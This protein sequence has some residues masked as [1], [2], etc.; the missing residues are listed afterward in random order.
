M[1]FGEKLQALRKE[2]GI[3]QEALAEMLGVSR[4][5]VSKW[6]SGATYPETEKI[7]TLCRMYD[8]SADEL[9]LDQP[10]Q[11]MPE[12]LPPQHTP[13][14]RRWATPVLAAA[15]A[16]A[17]AV[18]LWQFNRV[19]HWKLE[20]L[21]KQDRLAA[22]EDNLADHRVTVEG[23]QEL[24][25]GLQTENGELK[26]QLAAVPAPEPFSDPQQ[27]EEA[28]R[29]FFYRFGQ[30]WR[31]DYLP[32]FAA[33]QAPKES[34]DYLMWAYT[35]NAGNWSAEQDGTMS[36][37]YVA[38]RVLTHFAVADLSHTPLWKTWNF[39]GETYT[40]LP[41]GLRELPIY[42]FRS[43]ESEVTEGVRV[44][45]VEL[46]ECG[47]AG[48]V[49]PMPEDYADLEERPPESPED[50]RLT[51]RKVQRVTFTWGHSG[52]CFRENAVEELG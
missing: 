21:D 2:R 51:P 47:L 10:G 20:N 33:G 16:L 36:R 22:L 7:L 1:E 18:E 30:T 38:H 17:V 32:E 31:L 23:L 50:S 41:Q 26:E 29:R 11:A 24:V 4:Q 40:A 3:S 37:D 46:V 52:P 14:K 13:R 34:A 39:D 49:L 5:A 9:L 44:Y 45:T 48:G 27:A 19:E 42:L 8:L 12:M 15:L 43:L 35:V 25:A 6:E 28:L